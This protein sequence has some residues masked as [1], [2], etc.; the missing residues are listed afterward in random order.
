M[1]NKKKSR[2]E[3]FQEAEHQRNDQLEKLSQ[4]A[5]ELVISQKSLNKLKDNN[6]ILRTYHYKLKK[7][8]KNMNMNLKGL[9][10]KMNRIHHQNITLNEKYIKLKDILTDIIYQHK[11]LNKQN[12]YM[13]EKNKKS[14][15][16]INILKQASEEEI[17]ALLIKLLSKLP[18][19][20]HLLCEQAPEPYLSGQI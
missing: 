18:N 9:T 15:K 16:N 8:Y 7:N 12:N 11:K 6:H 5:E 13:I 2:I 1:P 17:I 19:L 20:I 10:S 3:I 14:E 4:L